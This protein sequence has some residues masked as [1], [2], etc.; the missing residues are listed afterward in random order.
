MT[1]LKLGKTFVEIPIEKKVYPFGAPECGLDCYYQ[2]G[3][4]C[5]LDKWDPS[6][7]PAECMK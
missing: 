4:M 1:I 6:P 3:G 5:Q 2:V 7:E